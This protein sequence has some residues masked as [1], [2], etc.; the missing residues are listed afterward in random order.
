MF[1]GYGTP[2]YYNMESIVGDP[3]D[4]SVKEELL[5]RCSAIL[6]D[7]LQVYEKL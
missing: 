5:E 4:D 7:M 3:A 2:S 1:I 6:E